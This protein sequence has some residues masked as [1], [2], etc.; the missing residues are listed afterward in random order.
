MTSGGGGNFVLSFHDKKLKISKLLEKLLEQE[1]V[2]HLS[3]TFFDKTKALWAIGA[4]PSHL[5]TIFSKTVNILLDD[6]QRF[7]THRDIML[8]KQIGK[9]KNRIKSFQFTDSKILKHKPSQNLVKAISYLSPAT[10]HVIRMENGGKYDGDWTTTIARFT[11]NQVGDL[12]KLLLSRKKLHCIVNY[13]L[14]T[15]LDYNLKKLL[16]TVCERRRSIN[17][18][19]ES[20]RFSLHGWEEYLNLISKEK[21][22]LYFTML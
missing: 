5:F 10:V 3:L 4:S 2:Y 14:S 17:W 12:Y 19:F 6:Y 7:L 18:L 16:A 9:Y 11:C 1:R 20:F 13:R 15:D 21:I 22:R 8:F